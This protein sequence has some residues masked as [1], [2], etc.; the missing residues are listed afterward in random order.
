[1]A[2]KTQT[3]KQSLWTAADKL[4]NNMSPADYK[5]VVLGLIFL[6]Y[7]SDS[8]EARHADNGRESAGY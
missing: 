4:R 7:I 5:Y 3:L 6:K 1:M 2:D 8:F